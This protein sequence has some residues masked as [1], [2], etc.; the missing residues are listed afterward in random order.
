MP[1]FTPQRQ[2]ILVSILLVVV[3]FAVYW[4]VRSFD[5][6]VYDDRGYVTK[7]PHVVSGLKAANVIWAFKTTEK[8]NWHPLT[9]LSYMLDC[10]LFGVNS[11]RSHLVNLF[12]HAVNSLMLFWFW[13]R[14]TG[15]LWPS[16]FV[17]ALFAWH[18]LHIESVAWV[19]ERKD[20]LSTFF[21]LLA[22]LSYASYARFAGGWRYAFALLFFSLGLMT[23]PMLVTL[24]FLLL[25]LD[26]WPLG[27]LRFRWAPVKP[28]NSSAKPA[29][30][31]RLIAE[32]IPFFLLAA[33]SS[34][35]TFIAQKKGGAMQGIAALPV[36]DRISNAVLSYLS[37]LG[38]MFWPV[39]LALPYP[40]PAQF[41]FGPILGAALVLALI[42][43]W[44]VQQMRSR[45]YLLTGWCWFLGT[46]VPVIG[47][48]Q[49]GLQAMA[50]RYT[51][52]PFIGLFVMV[53]WAIADLAPQWRFRAPTF[54][55]F[56]IAA[57]L[58]CLALTRRQLPYWKNSETLFSHTLKVSPDNSV[59]HHNLG[60]F[61]VE[62][63]NLD[64]GI[65]HLSKAL[66][67]GDALGGTYYDLGL[68]LMGKGRIQQAVDH[69]REAVRV[70]PDN[71]QFQTQLCRG[72]IGLGKF[73]EA[74]QALQGRPKDAGWHSDL[75]EALMQHGELEKAIAHYREAI[76]LKPD[77]AVALNNLAWLLATTWDARLR[78][79][80]EAVRL[81]E[82]AV[83]LGNE[84][85]FVGTLAA[86]YAEA[87]QFPKA[88][89][90]VEKAR[91]MAIF[92]GQTDLSDWYRKMLELYR[93][94]RPYHENAPTNALAP[95]TR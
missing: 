14:C 77:Y 16:A 24:P 61:Y 89:E 1:V 26:W 19:A 5:F 65:E 39:N 54:G 41:R 33:I 82:Q 62:E 72:L 29:S 79:G 27:R 31:A 86:A 95:P 71:Y 60:A 80:G 69:F 44:V 20:V 75:A 3:T 36:G 11:D 68:A 32:K 57:L 55:F 12:F 85:P 93:S 30:M 48:V 76:R 88:I 90:T 47:L 50:D 6:L 17:A 94:G 45:P 34:A 28:V 66:Q 78:D 42:S 70:E 92:K 83:R 18:P 63:G 37:Y 9:W 8:A 67:N 21:G 38:K 40:Y 58:A 25:L 81:A 15:A 43:V 4:P 84:T 91:A 35:V 51:Y 10:E 46:L 53:A 2:A 74:E 52:V 7:N 22:L 87:G 59:A 73:E 23:K 64:P 49:V 13:K 56:A